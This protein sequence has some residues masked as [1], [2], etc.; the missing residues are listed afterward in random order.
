[1]DRQ[2]QR[3]EYEEGIEYKIQYFHH[4][5]DSMRVGERIKSYRERER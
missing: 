2:I 1:M 4:V 3:E 5:R